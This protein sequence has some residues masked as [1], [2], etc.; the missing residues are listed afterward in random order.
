MTANE[1]CL[2]NP[3]PEPRTVVVRRPHRPPGSVFEVDEGRRGHDV[4]TVGV[5]AGGSTVVRLVAPGWPPALAGR[6]RCSIFPETG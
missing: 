1:A 6:R 3:D 4:V 2:H 5:P